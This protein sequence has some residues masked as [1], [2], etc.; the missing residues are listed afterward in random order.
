MK[1]TCLRLLE[2][3]ATALEEDERLTRLRLDEEAMLS[4]PVSRKLH[5]TMKQK[6]EA[7]Q[8]LRLELGENAEETK[9]AKRELAKAKE[10]LDLSEKG[11]AYRHS[12]AK[13]AILYQALDEIVY[14]P[15]R[16]HRAC[17]EKHAAH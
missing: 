6:G 4:D 10:E 17:K 12:Y 14:G 7:Y 8:R 13:V 9:R 2:D 1:Q 16:Q 11:E 3:F 5:E 15:Y